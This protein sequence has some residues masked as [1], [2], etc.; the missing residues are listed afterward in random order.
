MCV[1]VLIPIQV[2]LT[3]LEIFLG[4]FHNLEFV[5]IPNILR[6]IVKLTKIVIFINTHTPPI[7]KNKKL[8]NSNS[9]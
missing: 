5:E 8:N 6:V 7:T 4:I 2:Y 9:F 1:L 3:F